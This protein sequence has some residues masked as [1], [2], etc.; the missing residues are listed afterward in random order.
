MI[1][2]Q[3]YSGGNIIFGLLLIGLGIL[4]LLEQVL[5][6]DLWSIVWP[7]FVIAAGLLF[8]AG[9]VVGGRDA[10]ALAIP[11]SLIT[12]TGLILLYQYTFNTW[13]SWAYAWLLIV[14]TAL[15]IGMFVNG[16]WSGRIDLRR[17]GGMVALTGLIM[18]AIAGAVFEIAFGII[19][20][21]SAGQILW[22]F[23]LIALGILLLFWRSLS[24]LLSPPST[25]I[26]PPGDVDANQDRDR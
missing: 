5:R 23:M 17:A 11:G 19:G 7:Y 21:R 18:F 2:Q 16:W 14:P 25:G 13:V 24:A 20:I 12:T 15:G 3:K 10:G 4:F 8:F 1:Q 9:M 6:I 22:P 26:T